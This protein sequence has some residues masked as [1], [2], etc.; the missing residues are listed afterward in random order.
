[1]AQCG[2]IAAALDAAHGS[3][4]YGEAVQAARAALAKPDSLASARVLQ[5]MAAEHG[6]SFVSFTR[7]R[8]EATRQALLALPFD[9]AQQ[10]RFE[11]MTHASVEDQRKIEAADTMPFENYRQQYLSPERLGLKLQA[12]PAGADALAIG[13]I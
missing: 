11:A 9:A 1:M 13:T 5:A 6:N 3:T 8:S 7:A 4:A 2:P 12:A 10:A